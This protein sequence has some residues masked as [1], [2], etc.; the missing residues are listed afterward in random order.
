MTGPY[1][2]ILGRRYDR[3]LASTLT[4]VPHHYDVATGDPRL[5]GALV[6]VDP[7][8]GRA[9]SIRRISVNQAETQQLMTGS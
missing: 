6:S 3:V 8:S 9:L 4:N 7:A 5:C 2:S 1:D